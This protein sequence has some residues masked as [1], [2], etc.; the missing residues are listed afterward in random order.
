MPEKCQEPCADLVRVE[1]AL[2]KLQDQNSESH[3]EIFHRLNSLEQA[4]AAQGPQLKAIL[5]KLDALT[6]KVEA[7]EKKPASR[8]ESLVGQIIGLVVA[9]LVGLAVAK[10]GL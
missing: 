10:I 5:D 9:A 8:W 3:K 2:H 6:V 1:N 4:D 7:L